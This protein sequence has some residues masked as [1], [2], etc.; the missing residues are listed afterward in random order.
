MFQPQP[1]PRISRLRAKAD[2]DTDD[3][4]RLREWRRHISARDEGKCRCCGVLTIR[5]GWL[6]PRRAEC[7]HVEPRANRALRFET[8]NG[9]LLCRGCHERVTGKVNDKLTI[10]GTAW[11]FGQDMLRYIDA[12]RPVLFEEAV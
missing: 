12:D 6:H 5:V 2:K 4:K 10:R 11:F 3:A 9:L 1:K 7:H 8:R